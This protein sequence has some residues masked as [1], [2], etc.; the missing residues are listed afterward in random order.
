MAAVEEMMEVEAG[1][2]VTETNQE[3]KAEQKKPKP[4]HS[5][6]WYNRIIN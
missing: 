6:P 5:L 1:P 4:S 3:K 2:A